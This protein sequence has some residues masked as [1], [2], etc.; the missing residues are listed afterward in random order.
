M[1]NKKFWKIGFKNLMC[2]YF[3]D[4]IKV[5]VFAFNMSYIRQ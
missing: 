4:T 5:E 2:Y 3:D 1:E